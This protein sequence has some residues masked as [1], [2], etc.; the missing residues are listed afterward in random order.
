MFTVERSVNSDV[1]NLVCNQDQ[2]LSYKYGSLS[3][4]LYLSEIKLRL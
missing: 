1:L 4:I 3:I 2:F